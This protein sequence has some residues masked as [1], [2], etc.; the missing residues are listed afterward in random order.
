[1][2]IFVHIHAGPFDQLAKFGHITGVVAIADGVGQHCITMQNHDITATSIGVEMQGDGWVLA[3]MAYF[4]SGRT[5][6]IEN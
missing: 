1:M 5:G 3:N 4:G 2:L 6:V